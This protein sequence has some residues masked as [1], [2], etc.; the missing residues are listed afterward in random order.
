MEAKPQP[1]ARGGIPVSLPQLRT[2]A[3]QFGA[4]NKPVCQS[5]QRSRA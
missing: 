3:S 1:Q 4:S 2:V 5:D